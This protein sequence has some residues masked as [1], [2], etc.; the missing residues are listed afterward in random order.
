MIK[1]NIEWLFRLFQEPRRFFRQ[2]NIIKFIFLI[3]IK[4]N[5]GGNKVE[6]N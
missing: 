3:L 5:N 1:L 6:K 2:L 4:K